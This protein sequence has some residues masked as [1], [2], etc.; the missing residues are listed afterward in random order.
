MDFVSSL[1]PKNSKPCNSPKQ[2]PKPHSGYVG[3]LS[4][5]MEEGGS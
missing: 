5:R 4:Q 3:E 1:Q 2:D